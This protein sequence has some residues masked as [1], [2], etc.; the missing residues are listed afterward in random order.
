MDGVQAL[1]FKIQRVLPLIWTAESREVRPGHLFLYFKHYVMC[2]GASD[3]YHSTS[4]QYR[5]VSQVFILR[6]A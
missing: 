1:I 4:H 3:E 6:Y 2:M 5:T